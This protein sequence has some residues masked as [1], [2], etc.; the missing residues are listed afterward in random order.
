MNIISN[1]ISNKSGLPPGSLIHVGTQR[2]EAVRISIIDY[3]SA[4]FAKIESNNASETSTFKNSKT[5][6]WINV[7][8]L[9]DIK[10]IEELG[11][12]FELHPL[13][14]EDV[15][16]TKSR[17]KFEE[18]D[19]YT[20]VSLKMLG[21][22]LKGGEIVN[23]QV[24]FV[25]GK[26]WLISFQ[27][28]EGDIFDSIRFRLEEKKG[29][30]REKEAD[31]LLYRLIDTI[32]DNYF[33]ITENISDKIEALEEE[34]LKNA[35]QDTLHQIQNLKKELMS[36][37]RAV[38]PLREVISLLQKE[39]NNLINKKTIRFLRDVY[40]HTI[41]INEMIE[42]Q[43]DA[44]GNLMDLHLSGVSNKMN[45][46]MQTLTIIATIFIPLTF[47]A[48]IYGMNFDHIPELHWKHGYAAVWGVM[49]TV[50]VGMLL[51]FK[52]KKWL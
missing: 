44:V 46:V 33:H 36:L 6:S 24:S 3:N 28:H 32:V 47:I 16:N 11:H 41:Q 42:M 39:E 18:F 31:Y 2:A 23:E 29:V 1:K 19:D 15:L 38:T 43:R 22:G 13:L 30:I 48:G 52:K 8:G 50:I 45:Q 9:H 17:P 49:V 40:E 27:E 7:D 21:L 34:I 4:S 26:D 5:I 10:K 51:Y 14:L 12:I 37:R 25:L 20:F 35:T